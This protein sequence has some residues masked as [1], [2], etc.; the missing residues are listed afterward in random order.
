EAFVVGDL[1]FAAGQLASDFKT[2]VPPEARKQAGFPFYGSD[3]ELQTTYILQ[4]LK[5]TFQAP[6]PPAP[7]RVKAQGLL[8]HPPPLPPLRRRSRRTPLLD[9]RLVCPALVGRQPRHAPPHFR[10]L[11]PS[12]APPSRTS[13]PRPRPPLPPRPPAGERFQARRPDPRKNP[14]LTSTH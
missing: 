14:C 13:R 6:R 3:I 7:P 5:K 12:S 11:P 1:V 8:P 2:G 9:M 10:L 4:N